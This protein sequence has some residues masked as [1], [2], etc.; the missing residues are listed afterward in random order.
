MLDVEEKISV[1]K[2]CKL[3]KISRNCFYYHPKLEI[4]ENEK[5]V[6]LLKEQYVLT[7][8]YGYRKM[9]VWLQKQ[10]FLVNEKR[11]RRLMKKVCWKTIYRAP[12]TTIASKEHE[13]V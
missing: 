5:I 12:R 7:P 1:H 6:Q 13:K 10:G 8:F 4:E 9:T 11:V 2:Q 3:L